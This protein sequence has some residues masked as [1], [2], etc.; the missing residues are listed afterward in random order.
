MLFIW[1]VKGG[2]ALAN[3]C[4]VSFNFLIQLV[5]DSPTF[6]FALEREKVGFEAPV[7]GAGT[8]TAIVWQTGVH[9]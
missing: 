1:V 6:L 4:R 5:A 8:E 7:A 9:A 3:L 2:G